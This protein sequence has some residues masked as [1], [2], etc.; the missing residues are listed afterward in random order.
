MITRENILYLIVLPVFLQVL[1]K[2]YIPL[3]K[4]GD[5]PCVASVGFG[6]EFTLVCHHSAEE[7]GRLIQH[8]LKSISILTVQIVDLGR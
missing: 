3:L 5:P 1:N 8:Y 2:Q 4:E 6:G 7:H